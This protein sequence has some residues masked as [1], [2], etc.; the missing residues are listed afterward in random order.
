MKDKFADLEERKSRSTFV[1]VAALVL[2]GMFMVYRWST[3]DWQPIHGTVESVG[4]SSATTA[5]GPAVET[6]SVRLSDGKVV[7]A[8]VAGGVPLSVGDQVRLVVRPNSAMGV[9]YEVVAK[10]NGTA[11]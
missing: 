7:V 1:V 10:L 9:P 11:P 8:E 3:A 4:A 5:Y 2:L 6:A